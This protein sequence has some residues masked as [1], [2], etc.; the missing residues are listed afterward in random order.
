M[1][2]PLAALSRFARKPLP[3]NIGWAHTLGSLLLFYLVLQAVTGLLLALYYNPSP[4]HARASLTYLRDELTLGGLVYALHHHGAGFV[5]VVAA[6]H[7][8]RGHFMA[9][10]K[11]PRGMLWSTG[12]LLGGLLLAF[13]FTGALLPFDQW[14]CQT[15]NVALSLV[16]DAPLVGDHLHSLLTGGE[17]L[18]PVALSRFYILHVCVLPMLLLVL[19]A[20]HLRLLQATGPAGPAA[21]PDGPH[22][23]FFPYQ[24]AKD[25][26]VA[27]LGAVALVAVAMLVPFTDSG[28]PD[29]LDASYVPHPEWY[30]LPHYG[31]L[32]L[33]PSGWQE[34]GSFYAPAGLFGLLL[35]LPL[36]DR[37]RERRL[38]RRPI[39]AVLGVVILFGGLGLGIFGAV[40]V[41]KQ[42]GQVV[43]ASH[44]DD[45][46]AR[47]QAVF[48][49]SACVECHLLDGEGQEYGPDLTHLALRVRDGFL[50]SFL[51][52]PTDF[53]DEPEM[54]PFEGTEKELSDL[55]AFLNSLR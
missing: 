38:R 22:R 27:V 21:G 37:R 2:S 13:P 9:A 14:G 11:A 3:R 34:L 49:E 55:L 25:M 29:L 28:A 20:F 45:P 36:L 40:E 15:A 52:Q 35:F 33:L 5:L 8:V 19:G 43:A 50:E 10:Y 16:A 32:R 44:D 54:L 31:L 4:E 42:R 17:G 53:F 39:A 6:V 26:T 12:V 46:V 30:F 23:P 47:G 18:G 1:S 41:A 7:L 48:L 24:A 51:R